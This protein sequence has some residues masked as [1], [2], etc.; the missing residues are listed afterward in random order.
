[1]LTE[2]NE[3][4][5]YKKIHPLLIENTDHLIF[6]SLYRVY[7]DEQHPITEEAPGLYDVIDDEYFLENEK[8][9]VP[10]SKCE[11]YLR[12]EKADEPWTIV[13]PVIS[14]SSYRLDLLLCSF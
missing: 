14:F 8:Y 13:R 9:A 11:D 2:Y 5:D 3:L 4:E 7:A 1:M 10:K 6:L 12:N